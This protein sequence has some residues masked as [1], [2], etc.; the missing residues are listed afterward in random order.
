MKE[1]EHDFYNNEKNIK[2]YGEAIDEVG[3]WDS[4]RII[5]HKYIDKNSNILD[6]GCGAGRTTINLFKDGY[7]DIIGLDIAEN[8]IDYAIN[9]CQTNNL[10]VDF[11]LGDATN[12]P[13]PDN[14]MDA[15]IF[16]YNGMQCIPKKSARDKV[17]KEI[18]RILKSGGIYIFTAH[19]RDDGTRELFWQEEKKRWEN[20]KEDS[21]YEMFGDLIT[22]D[23]TGEDAFVHFSSITEM[24]EFIAQEDFEI[25]EYISRDHI[26]EE[27]EEVKKFSNNTIFWIIKKR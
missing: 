27:R 18:N 6:V 25:I 12:I 23:Q 22:K 2:R 14:S 10:N 20:G 21:R 17:L 7:K 24:K 13:F 8:L 19:D 11:I 3:L 15:V 26:C 16:S 1:N 9:Y 4:E 5:F